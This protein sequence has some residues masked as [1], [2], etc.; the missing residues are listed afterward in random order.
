MTAPTDEPSEKPADQPAAESTRDALIAAGLHFF[1]HKGFAAASTREIAARAG[2]NVAAIA[3]HFGGKEGLRLACAEAVG[4]RIARV[5]AALEAGEP[6]ASPAEA[7]AR[8]EAAVRAMTGYLVAAPE[9][10]DLAAFLLREVT[11]AG[12]GLD[13]LYETTIAPRHADLC[14]LWGLRSARS[15]ARSESRVV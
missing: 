2:A 5:L 13:R 6:P 7:R 11:E 15:V 14:R 9:A 12:P 3:Y 1:G 10:A 4:A 8:L